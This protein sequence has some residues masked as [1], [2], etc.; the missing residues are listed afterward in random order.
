MGYPKGSGFVCPLQ[1]SYLWEEI[2]W[3]QQCL[4]PS[5]SSSS[6]TLQTRLKMLQ[7][8]SL[9]QVALPPPSDKDPIIYFTLPC[10]LLPC[11]GPEIN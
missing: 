10:I 9:L 3:L 7:A 6:C 11:P 8:V 2:S 5:Q 4:S 1:V